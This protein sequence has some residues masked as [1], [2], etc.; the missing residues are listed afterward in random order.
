M[1]TLLWLLSSSLAVGSIPEFEWREAL[2]KQAY[3]R[4]R[5]VAKNWMGYS[6]GQSIRMPADG[7]HLS[8]SLAE[9]S[10]GLETVSEK[11]ISKNIDI[12][13]IIGNLAINHEDSDLFHLYH[14]LIFFGEEEYK[15]IG[16]LLRA[17]DA[18]YPAFVL[19][20]Q[21]LSSDS[22]CVGNDCEWQATAFLERMNAN[23]KGDV[24]SEIVMSIDKGS[25][26]HL[27]QGN[28]TRE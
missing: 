10:E 24:F 4:S 21:S 14:V 13:L 5:G 26:L 7:L 1:A 23:T 2:L 3:D 8:G 19:K 17:D 15:G 22:D 16:V 27:L 6:V 20:M 28:L 25:R 18:Q 12:R 9:V 11:D